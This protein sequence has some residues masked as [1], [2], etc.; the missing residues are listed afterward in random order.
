MEKVERANFKNTIAMNEKTYW[1][2]IVSIVALLSFISL[3]FI[4]SI[5]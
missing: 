3:L 5:W 4:G 1:L 2:I